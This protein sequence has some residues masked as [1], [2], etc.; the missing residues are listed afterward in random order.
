M[1][2]NIL[3]DNDASSSDEIQISD[4]KPVIKEVVQ[5]YD[6]IDFDNIQP[7]HQDGRVYCPCG[8]N[9]SSELIYAYHV[10]TTNSSKCN[11]YARE[12]K[13]TTGWTQR[14]VN[15]VPYAN[16]TQNAVI[17][18]GKS[19]GLFV[20]IQ[21]EANF[22][23]KKLK[24]CLAKIPSWTSSLC[25]EFAEPIVSVVG[26]T[27]G[28][29]KR[30]DSKPPKHLKK[31]KNIGGKDNNNN[32][33]DQPLF[34]ASDEDIFL[35][36]KSNRI[37]LCN[38][39]SSK[40]LVNI[41]SA[42]LKTF[43]QTIGFGHNPTKEFR[44]NMGRDL[45]GFID[46]TRNPDH[47]LRALVDQTLIFPLDDDGNHVA[48]S[49]MYAG[50]F[51]HNLEKFHK[52][53]DKEKSSIIGRDITKV[54][55]HRGYD[56]RAENPRLD[57]EYYRSKDQKTGEVFDSRFHTLRGHGSMYRQAMPFISGPDQ[58]LYFICFSRSLV[59]IDNALK[60]MA[61]HFQGDGSTDAVLDITRAVTSNYYYCPSL[62]ELKSLRKND[63]ELNPNDE[64]DVGMTSE[65]KLRIVAEYCTNCGYFTIYQKVKQ[66][67]ESVCSD[68]EFIENPKNPRLASF[69]LSTFDGFLLFSKLSL[70]DGMNNYPHCFPTSAKL[71]KKLREYLK[72]ED[73]DYTDEEKSSLVWGSSGWEDIMDTQ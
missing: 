10:E 24:R 15:I 8:A 45:T 60:R 11:L 43:G 46:G 6:D 51:I 30:W 52:L 4:P 55:S 23:H 9:F 2:N 3:R 18:H 67:I 38:M 70:P 34:P 65:K 58:G 68:V 27:S 17:D 37:D 53:S 12:K 63:N 14:M 26:I 39:L 66:I 44:P 42:G 29:W 1:G 13:D 73:K 22:D 50:K 54:K 20:T 36:I 62:E 25:T 32:S 5:K 59:E 33:N 35:F 57:E 64:E 19:H 47:L 48:G 61:G 49:Y 21:L 31:F 16:K 7:T 72:L 71:Q 28:L 56:D 40:I 41:K 69:E